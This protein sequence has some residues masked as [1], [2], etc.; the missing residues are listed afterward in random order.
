MGS[1]E[2]IMDHLAHVMVLPVV[3]HNQNT[4]PINRRGS[5]RAVNDDEILSCLAGPVRRRLRRLS[6]RVRKQHGRRALNFADRFRQFASKKLERQLQ[7]QIQTTKNA[8]EKN[9]EHTDFANSREGKLGVSDCGLKE[10]LAK[11]ERVLADVLLIVNMSLTGIS[12]SMEA[13]HP[14]L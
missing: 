1:R 12:A 2:S 7:Q 10:L 8:I 6:R 14:E 9:A 3:Y 4:E 11:N 13:C 5:K